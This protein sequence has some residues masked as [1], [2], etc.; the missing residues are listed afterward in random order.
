MNGS[1]AVKSTHKCTFLCKMLRESNNL[2]SDSFDETKLMH[3]SLP[4]SGMFHACD[5]AGEGRD[6]QIFMT[7]GGFLQSV[8]NM[9]SLL[10]NL[11]RFDRMLT[12]VLVCPRVNQMT[13]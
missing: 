4:F 6:G 7:E 10:S 3:A 12:Q 8:L 11:I 5:N 1:W 2:Y 9:Q 13:N